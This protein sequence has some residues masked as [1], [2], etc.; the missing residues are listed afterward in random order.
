MV[1]VGFTNQQC[2]RLDIIASHYTLRRSTRLSH[3]KHISMPNALISPLET[4][5]PFNAS[6]V[7]IVTNIKTP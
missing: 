7:K 1:K 3:W 6:F 5:L 2:N 4:N